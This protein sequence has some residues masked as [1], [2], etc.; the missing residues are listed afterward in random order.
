MRATCTTAFLV[1][2]N[3]A[4]S[5]C[6]ETWTLASV[7][8]YG[9]AQPSRH[10]H[11]SPVHCHPRQLNA[12]LALVLSSKSCSIGELS[13]HDI[14]GL[15]AIGTSTVRCQR[16]YAR[17]DWLSEIPSSPSRFWVE[18]SHL[19]WHVC[20]HEPFKFTASR[21]GFPCVSIAPYGRLSGETNTMTPEIYKT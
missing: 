10:A 6:G 16:N 7:I 4:R 21:Y 1:I 3:E 9:F 18:V 19:S 2:I 5:L 11:V 14:F 15:F 8:T 12:E 17:R 20:T 13:D